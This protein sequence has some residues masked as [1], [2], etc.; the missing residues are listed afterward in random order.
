[1]LKSNKIYLDYAASV[2]AN[3]SSIHSFGVDAKKKLEGARKKVA[4][5][6]NARSEEIIF[7]SGGTESNNLAIQGI[8]LA[9]HQRKNKKKIEKKL[10]H[11]IIT[12]I[13]QK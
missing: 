11:I 5:V 1:M 6:L 10:P 9:W 8:V 4:S 3:P 2:G 13:E 12:N 7:T